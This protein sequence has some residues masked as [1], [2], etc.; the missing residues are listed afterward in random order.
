VKERAAAEAVLAPKVRGTLALAGAFGDLPLDA[1]V[2]CGSVTG[3]AGGFGQV[4]YC[5]ANAFL[6]AVAQAGTAFAGP[7]LSVDWGNWLE[8]GMA[9]EVVA[10]SAFRALQRGVV[11]T[12]MTHPI[13]TTAHQDPASGTAWCTGTIGPRTH[14]VLDEHRLAGRA[15]LPGTGHLATVVAAARAIGTGD[16]LVE[17]R[18]V[19][20]LEPLAVDDDSQAE[21]R[22]AFADGGDDLDF[23]LTS[24]SAGRDRAHVRGTV[25]RVPAG[26]APVHDLAAIRARCHVAAVA[27]EVTFSH[28]QLFTFGPRWRSLGRVDV[29]LAEE[30]ARLEAPGVV[31]AE[32]DRWGGLHPALLDEAVSFAATRVNGKFLPMGYGRLLVRSPLSG[33]LWSH[34]RFRE[35]DSDEILVVDVAMLDDDGT[36]LVSVTELVL[37]RIDADAVRADLSVPTRAAVT[38]APVTDAKGIAPADGV[39][40]LRRLLATGIGPQVLVTPA[41]ARD[42][43]AGARALT[44][45]TVEEELTQAASERPERTL[46]GEYLAPGTELER[47]LCDLWQDAL[48]LDRV[49]VTDDFF[50]AGGNSLVAVQL[51]AGIRKETGERLPMRAL[52]DAS[53]VARMAGV[54]EGLRAAGPVG[55]DADEPPIVPLSREATLSRGE[56]R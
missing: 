36:E 16:G 3:V 23:Q 56:T 25:A 37:R 15:V 54:I 17:L 18:D 9:A 12:P 49:S 11:S 8:V 21:V 26:P 51:L 46:E 1:V 27:Q 41:H 44:Q 35:T 47:A 5:G 19:A 52:F 45:R 43:I 29:G 40:A 14:W 32:L 55:G 39:A 53:T 38:V 33:R 30:L 7:I 42:A 10:P 24:R 2:L 48:G 34:L 4:D 6:D 28:T 22:V 50:E 13:L 31:A 20:L